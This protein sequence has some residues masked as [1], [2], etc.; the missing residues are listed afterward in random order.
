MRPVYIRARKRRIFVKGNLTGYRIV[1]HNSLGRAWYQ[2]REDMAGIFIM[3][4]RKGAAK[5]P[6]FK[7][8]YYERVVIDSTKLRVIRLKG[9]K[10]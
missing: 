2:T 7:L 4:M 1:T 6:K 5:R 9:I 8:K 3:D 10:R